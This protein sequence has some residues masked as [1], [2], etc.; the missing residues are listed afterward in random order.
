MDHPDLV[1]ENASVIDGT[2]APARMMEVAIKG[3]RIA[4]VA[5]RLW[6]IGRRR[7]STPR[8]R[9]SHRVSSTSTRT[10]NSNRSLT[11]APPARTEG[12][13]TEI[14]GNCGSRR[15]A[16]MRSTIPTC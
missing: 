10:A 16:R 11:T 7:A 8:A 15:S 9:S 12:V 13:T 3:E 6:K 5:A 4:A 1:I 2:G 14:S